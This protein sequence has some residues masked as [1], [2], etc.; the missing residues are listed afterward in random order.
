MIQLVYVHLQCVPCI[1][2]MYRFK[3]TSDPIFKFLCYKYH[4]LY[5][6]L[7]GP[8]A[9]LMIVRQHPIVFNN[10]RRTSILHRI[11]M[12]KPGTH[13]YIPSILVYEFIFW[14]LDDRAIILSLIS[15]F[16]LWQ[17]DVFILNIPQGMYSLS[18][19]ASLDKTPIKERLP[20]G[21]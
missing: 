21:M 15:K 18:D 2:P 4:L 8:F 14:K 20:M 11:D 17:D 3:W 19:K 16:L 9:Y 5:L 13:I 1:L 10:P 12:L 6:F 7:D